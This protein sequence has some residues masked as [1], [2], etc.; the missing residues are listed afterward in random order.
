MYAG[1]GG[2][3]ERMQWVAVKLSIA[4]SSR[5]RCLGDLREV[6]SMQKGSGGNSRFI[7]DC[8]GTDLVLIKA[9]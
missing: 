8:F 6:Q 5:S 2:R 1:V 4:P 9:L 3:D 7:R